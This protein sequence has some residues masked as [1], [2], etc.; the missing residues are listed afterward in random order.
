MIHLGA[1]LYDFFESLNLV[2][3]FYDL[4]ILLKNYFQM[5]DFFFFNVKKHVIYDDYGCFITLFCHFFDTK[6]VNHFN[7]FFFYFINIFK[8]IKKITSYLLNLT[9]NHYVM[10]HHYFQY[11]NLNHYH[12]SFLI[13]ITH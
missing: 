11:N 1:I 6:N 7:D 12:Q 13:H 3:Y 5:N 10:N 8:H 2:F 9:H 4:N